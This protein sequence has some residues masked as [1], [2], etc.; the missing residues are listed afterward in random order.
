MPVRRPRQERQTHPP[1]EAG[2]MSVGRMSGLRLFVQD[3][4]Y[5]SQSTIAAE[6]FAI[7]ELYAD[8]TLLL[9]RRGTRAAA[10]AF[11][12]TVMGWA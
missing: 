11:Y 10:I 6:P 5:T 9:P 12:R 7:P 2:V 3:S 1:G 4:G 8:F